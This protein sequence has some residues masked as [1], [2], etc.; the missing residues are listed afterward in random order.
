MKRIMTF[1]LAA[2][3]CLGAADIQAG[4]HYDF[5]QKNGQNVLGAEVLAETPVDYTIRLAYVPTPIKI[6]KANLIER[7]KLSATQPHVSRG[8]ELRRDFVLYGA[9]AYG[10]FNSGTVASIFRSGYRISAGADW[11]PLQ[12]PFWRIHA[13]TA[14]VAFSRFA[15]SPRYIQIVDLHVGPRFFL[16][17]WNYLGTGFYASPLVGLAYV[18]LHG[19]TFDSSYLNLTTLAA[20]QA[21]RRLGPVSIIVQVTANSLFD[22]S[23]VFTSTA[24]GLAVSYP[25]T[26]GAGQLYD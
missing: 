15:E 21:E 8:V 5:F 24:L 7:P 14:T 2:A 22:K 16:G 3:T 9:V 20:L 1:I 25:L 17:Q 13:V 18:N 6:L 4:K 19:Y 23:Q 10:A 12:K 11:L 26:A